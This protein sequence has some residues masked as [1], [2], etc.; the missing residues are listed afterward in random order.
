MRGLCV[1]LVLGTINFT[2]LVV[3]TIVNNA[4]R[5]RFRSGILAYGGH[6]CRHVS[7]GHTRVTD[8]HCVYHRLCALLVN[9]ESRCGWH[10]IPFCARELNQYTDR[11]RDG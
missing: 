11:G 8:V 6:I 5:T 2:D 1:Q 9:V 3:K 7:V 10:D 4:A